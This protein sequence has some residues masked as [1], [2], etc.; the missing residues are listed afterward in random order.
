MNRVKRR[1]EES[2]IH[3]WVHPLTN[4]ERIFLWGVRSKIAVVARILGNVDE[5]ELRRGLDSARRMHPLVGCKI[6]FDDHHHAGCSAEDLPE[7][8]LR[9]T[10]RKSKTQ[11]FDEIRQEHM[12]PFKPETGPLVRFVLIYSP[13]VSELIA[14][15]QHCICDGSAMANLI[16][17]ILLFYAHPEQ[18]VKTVLPPMLTDFVLK[19]NQPSLQLSSVKSSGEATISGYNELWAKGGHRFTQAD[20]CEVFDAYWK[21]FRY[22]MALLQLDTEETSVLVARCRENG[23][24]IIS[25]VTAAFAGARR[26]IQGPIPEDKRTIGIPFDLRRHLDPGKDR[27]D[28]GDAFCFFAG[29]F[30][31]KFSY[32]RDRS[33]WENARELHGILQERVKALDTS[34]VD[35]RHFDPTLIDAIFSFAPYVQKMPEAFKKTEN[36]SSFAHDTKN[37]SLAISQKILSRHP[38]MI[39]TNLGRL[40]FPEKYG[41]LV[42]D[43]MY[44]APPASEIIP[45]ILGGIGACGRLTFT[46][47]YLENAEKD[48]PSVGEDMVRIR[49]RALEYIG[50]PEKV[51]DTAI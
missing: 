35:M 13:K 44:F 15:G 8:M 45:L 36:L 42:L 38:S 18:D 49:N 2:E 40:D 10:P 9:I 51:K 33:F 34:G 47:V 25:A 50:F 11:W 12:V 28:I 7:T 20:F 30:N 32:N 26:D 37:V 39:V 4:T 48:R 24:T 5:K 19:G 3:G 22:S 31:L 17:D 1:A 46:L 43:R 6:I 29:D 23:V 27:K 41:N 16:H 14:F 21:R